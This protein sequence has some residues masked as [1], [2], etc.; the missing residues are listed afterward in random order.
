MNPLSRWRM[1]ALTTALALLTLAAAAPAADDKSPSDP[2]AGDRVLVSK[3]LYEA[4]AD[5]KS[6]DAKALDH[7]LYT[8]LRDV[9]NQ[10]VDL[11]N[12]GDVNGCYQH[13]R[14]AL[15][16]LEP[17]LAHHP[18]LQ[19]AVK[20]GLDK[21]EKD[22][23]WRNKM[24]AKAMMP[25]PEAVPP[26]DVTRVKAF[27]LR[28]VFND[29]RSTLKGETKPVEKPKDEGSIDGKVL[30]DGK[31]LA[32]GKVTLSR[33]GEKSMS[34]DVANGSFK[35]AKV[36]AGTY[37]VAVT[38]GGVP[39]KYGDPKTSGIDT[40][41]VKGGNL[42]DLDLKSEPKPAGDTGTV[43][44]TVKLD[45]K[46]VAKA[47]VTFNDEK[48]EAVKTVEADADGKF[49]ADLPVGTYQ[50]TVT[51][52]GIPANYNDLKKPDSAL[53]I[54]VGK[55]KSVTFLGLRSGKPDDTP[56]IDPNLGTIEGVVNFKGGPKGLLAKGKLT[57]HDKD[58]KT[59]T[60]DV[61]NGEYKLV[62][63][64][65]GKYKVTI[66][67]EGVGAK[68]GDVKTTPL[69]LDIEKKGR[70]IPM[71]YGDVSE[72]PD[73]KPKPDKDLGS[74]SGLVTLD[75]KNLA[76][77]KVTA[78]D[79]DG[80]SYTGEIKDGHYKVEGLPPGKYS[81]G[82]TGDG[83]PAKAGDPKKS[84]YTWDIQKGENV[85]HS[86]NLKS[87]KPEDKPK[88]GGTAKGK[89]TLDGKAVE[90]V[91]V[92]FWDGLAGRSGKF[93]NA[94]TDKAGN[95][96]LGTGDTPLEPGKFM[97]LISGKDVPR[98]Y[99]KS[100]AAGKVVEVKKGANTLDFA[101]KSERK[102]PEA[103]AVPE[104]HK[105]LGELRA[106]GEQHYKAKAKAGGGFE[107]VLEGPNATLT[108][109]EAGK[110]VG[111][112][113]GSK[114]GP[115]WEIEEITVTGKMPPKLAP[116]KEGDLPWLLLEVKDVKVKDDKKLPFT[117]AYVQR[118]DTEGGV[119]PAKAPEKETDE[120]K[121]KY[122]ATYVFY[123]ADKRPEDKK[124]EDKKP[125]EKKGDTGTVSGKVTYK[126]KP[127]PGGNV[128]F[129]GKD[130]KSLAAAIH[131]DGTYSLE[132]VPPG[133]YKV[134][135]ETESL[136]KA[137]PGGGVPPKGGDKIAPP[138]AA[139]APKYVAIPV[140]YANPET[141]GLTYTVKTGKQTF[142][143]DLE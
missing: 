56:K 82:I 34:A 142:D 135:V 87:E 62:N 143:I 32:K 20:D 23:E 61:T 41:V 16:D 12:R 134:A 113:Y 42:L 30:L 137:A 96:E 25:N 11:Y 84:G 14:Q 141:S 70:N 43:E 47:K 35:F 31:P 37:Q 69:T 127:L 71:S 122:K 40:K 1:A 63:L 128:T 107:W 27:A 125:E 112:H 91:T 80:K 75:D 106:E 129:A 131:E 95:Y 15:T 130:G 97:V 72:K 24:A 39:A 66:T 21:A 100:D 101:L 60:S 50:M 81:V 65:I 123:F 92:S 64:P 55:G 22:P 94:Q 88:E 67:G 48:G 117:L 111:K 77:G 45:G 28:A 83:V 99:A 86:Y 98:K 90:G 118:V 140:K 68:Y 49:T 44:G 102:V 59:Y 2:K 108:D 13:F 119:A 78:T 115:V 58:G 36:P 85:P 103:V 19:K 126:G 7:Y 105:S 79:K 53:K 54:K 76:K 38:G 57:A 110:K 114:D 9:I 6:V 89:V 10:G 104:G 133:E 4:A 121:V 5:A 109:E 136:R 120:V 18:D 3:A 74:M 8:S 46:N 73:D 26:A 52:T 132:K 93:F 138:P 124:P 29:V 33:A 116:A 17:V 51:G 139:D